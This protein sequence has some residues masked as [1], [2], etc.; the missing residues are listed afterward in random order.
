MKQQTIEGMN[1]IGEYNEYSG[2]KL[3]FTGLTGS[4]IGIPIV[5]PLE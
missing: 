1:S 5:T 4:T 3:I 2:A